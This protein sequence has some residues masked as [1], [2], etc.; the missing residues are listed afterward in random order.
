MLW[1]CN[2]SV[3]ASPVLPRRPLL[4]ASASLLWPHR[5]HYFVRLTISS[6]LVVVSDLPIPQF[7]MIFDLS[8]AH[9][10]GARLIANELENRLQEHCSAEEARISNDTSVCKGQEAAQ[11]AELNETYAAQDTGHVAP[12]NIEPLTV[13]IA[14]LIVDVYAV[15]N[16]VVI[17]CCDRANTEAL[18]NILNLRGVD[19]V[20]WRSIGTFRI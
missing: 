17:V 12:T 3:P 14:M 7:R 10:H 20:G 5:E 18:D 6:L 1:S 16:S 9:R 11:S 19:D 13:Y 8:S 4:T 15:A 2:E